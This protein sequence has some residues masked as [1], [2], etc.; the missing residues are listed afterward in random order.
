MKRPLHARLALAAA[1]AALACA[2]ARATPAESA[3]RGL[4][5]RVLPGH[6]AEIDVEQIPAGPGGADVFEVETRGGRLVLRGNSGVSLGSALGWYFRNVAHL[7]ASWDGDN[8]SLAGPLPPV[9]ARVRIA[10]PYRFRAYLNFCTFNYSMSW[11]DRARWER[12]IDWM[13]LNGITLPLATTGQEAVWQATL[14]R[15]G[16]D[17]GEIRRYMV[18]PAFSAWQQLTNIEQWAG[19]LP[20]SWIDS[21]L[22]L[23]RFIL[24]RE[25][26]FGMTPILQGFSGCVPLALRARFPGARI[27][28]KPVWCEVPPGTSQLDPDDPLFE[29]AGRIFLEE[30][31]RLLGTDHLYAAD[32]FHESEPPSDAP[33]YLRRVGAR[34]FSLAD[35]VDPRATIVMQGW[36]IREGIV[37]GIPADRIL[38][39]DLTGEKW[40]ETQSFWGRPWVVGVLHNFGG[41]TCM[42]ANLPA[43][44][45]N[46]PALLA[47]P[48]GGRLAGLGVFPEAIEQNPVVY[49]LALGLAWRRSAPDLGDWLRAYVGA[50][51]GRDSPPAQ[52]AW[53]RLLA[54]VYA[55]RGSS[56]QMESPI[57]ARPALSLDRAS[58]WGDFERDYDPREV[59]GAWE[60]L[61]GAS[62]GLSSVD[63]YRYDV[64][65]VARQGLA[66]LS[67]PLF[68]EVADAYR[69]GDTRRFAEAKGRFIALIEDIDTLLGTRREFL[70]GRWLEDA[71]A[72]ASTPAERG[73]YERNAR[74][75]LTVWGPPGRSAF[76]HDY[77]GRQ[78]AGLM[79]GFYLQRWE[80]FF[81]F[82]EAQPA[83]YSDD[84]L[85]RVMNRVGDDA[86]PFYTVLS[87][88]EYRWCDSHDVFS[89]EPEGDSVLV[90][91][92][93]LEKWRPA[94]GALYPTF[95]WKKPS[96]P[97]RP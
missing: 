8:L 51:Y 78:W 55:Q 12:E 88:W 86:S 79:R 85:P 3:A 53:R 9:A 5:Q 72:W 31:T 2:P 62:A 7:Q 94:M 61:L 64:V 11:W 76:L 25:R 24:E 13:A 21:H 83:G 87:Q 84:G 35:A 10:S 39:L 75:L 95:A 59:W 34:L 49:D 63:T 36:T 20:Q 4:V 42:G 90:A 71:K 29:R 15:L 37:E 32:P 1:L 17:D 54:S 73:L 18:G 58:A 47:G 74:L 43:I 65:D 30:Q 92:Q 22:E 27:Q 56:P 6:A 16:M 46:A 68:G 77:A 33:E 38:V 69:S 14:R 57:L 26:S 89:R 96:L 67:L 45:G 70:L 28:L 19:P 40:R 91:R 97:P 52:G 80:K 44:A 48:G 66:D 81:A 93:L 23:G 41:R 60:Q 82:L 50:R